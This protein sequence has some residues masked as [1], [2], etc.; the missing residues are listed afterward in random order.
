MT[1]GAPTAAPRETALACL[2]AGIEAADPFRAARRALSVTDDTDG[3]ERVFTPDG[4]RTPAT[5]TATDTDGPLLRLDG[6]A[7][8]LDRYDRVLVL[9]AGKAA[10]RL[11]AGVCSSL[12]PD[13]GLV[14]T[15]DRGA[16]D[17]SPSAATL[18]VDVPDVSLPGSVAVR[19]AAHPV[20]DERG[21]AAARR[22]ET[23][24]EAADRQTLVVVALTG[25][26][27][28]LLPAPA[29]DLDLTALRVLTR[30]LLDAGEPVAAVNA[31]RR[32]CSRLQGGRLAA[33][34][35][36]ATTLAL[37]VSDVVGDDPGVVASGPTT[38]DP[39][40]Y[41]DALA[42]VE[43]SGLDAP[44]VREHLRAG[45][46]GAVPETPAGDGP[47]ADGA[48]FE[49][50]RT[51]VVASGRPSV[52][53]AASAAR[54][55]GYRVRTLS[56]AV[57]GEAAAVGRRLAGLAG[58]VRGPAVV[59]GA[60]ETT[61]TVHDGSTPP[62]AVPE[63]DRGAGGPNCELALAGACTLPTAAVLAAVDTD[64][65]DGPPGAGDRPDPAGALVDGA[66][67]AGDGERAAAERALSTHASRSLLRE[68][69]ALVVTGPT[70]TNVA[71]LSVVVVPE[72]Q[73]AGGGV[74]NK[75][76]ESR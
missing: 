66:T 59:L 30:D 45:A 61:V 19:A 42:V 54:D 27:S 43:R 60:G 56:T 12:T 1:D 13:D 18:T 5:A 17:D 29:G 50:V 62:G 28:A 22:V 69:G 48:A 10:D 36:P 21:L 26:G 68:W 31:V 23:L 75:T 33:R 9:G 63:D 14:V 52:A 38:P 8:A 46:A 64:G 16:G 72:R 49:R 34:L 32:H 11:A 6:D 15:D 58:A 67:V 44:A 76:K 74:F 37:A 57:E 3:V 35:A 24:A 39:T 70:G 20:P 47:G 53:A 25:G 73:D 71:D 4:P 65:R 7:W 40:T 55:R 41:G 51:A 2:R